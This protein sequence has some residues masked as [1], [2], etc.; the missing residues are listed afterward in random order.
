MY[1]IYFI[2]F[3]FCF[4]N[5]SFFV[6]HTMVNICGVDW[7]LGY[8][9]EVA[10]ASGEVNAQ[11]CS[12]RYPS[13]SD[14]VYRGIWGYNFFIFYLWCTKVDWQYIKACHSYT[15]EWNGFI[16]WVGWWCSFFFFI[17][18]SISY[19][20]Q[21]YN[22]NWLKVMKNVS[23]NCK[24]LPFILVKIKHFTMGLCSVKNSSLL[25]NILLFLL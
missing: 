23:V 10:A 3:Y 7:F 16:L 24:S 19:L 13:R 8:G 11:E 20:E 9:R 17:K 14:S 25:C 4:A 18:P 2:F 6:R 1:Y 21:Y 12:T 15:G 5:K 22:F